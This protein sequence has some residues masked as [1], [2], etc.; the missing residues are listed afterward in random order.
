MA[1]LNDTFVV[2]LL[3]KAGSDEGIKILELFA[4]FIV[5]NKD[6]LS[7]DLIKS[8]NLSTAYN[9][10]TK[11]FND[12]LHYYSQ[13]LIGGTTN[14]GPDATINKYIMQQMKN[15]GY[16]DPTDTSWKPR[17]ITYWSDKKLRKKVQDEIYQLIVDFE[18]YYNNHK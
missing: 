18:E 7:D 2:E 11:T 6:R 15:R 16:D 13:S 17:F 4:D 12:D 9:K 10:E 14:Y 8:T 5:E 1:K 3:Q